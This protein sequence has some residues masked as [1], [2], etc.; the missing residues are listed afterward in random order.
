MKKITY[1]N[2]HI[3]VWAVIKQDHAIEGNIKDYIKRDKLIDNPDFSSPFENAIRENILKNTKGRRWLW[4]WLCVDNPSFYLAEIEKKDWQSVHTVFGDKIKLMEIVED[5]VYSE[6]S[7]DKKFLEYPAVFDDKRHRKL[8]FGDLDKVNE[9]RKTKKAKLDPK[10][11]I[12]NQILSTDKSYDFHRTIWIKS[13]NK[14]TLTIVDGTHRNISLAWDYVKLGK[15]YKNP[16]Y[17][18]VMETNK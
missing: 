9:L 15:E 3:P 5:Y 13:R 17:A 12:T 14:N 10:K 1:I 11:D 7:K 4:E 8:V 16:I 18:I 2:Q 6:K